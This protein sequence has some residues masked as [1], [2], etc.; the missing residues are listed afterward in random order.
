MANNLAAL[1]GHLFTTNDFLVPEHTLDLLCF[2]QIGGG[3]T[4]RTYLYNNIIYVGEPPS[5]RTEFSRASD[6]AYATGRILGPA[7]KCINANVY[8][9]RESSCR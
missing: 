2:F 5:F 8:Y 1:Q 3:W 4:E 9:R 7:R 6:G